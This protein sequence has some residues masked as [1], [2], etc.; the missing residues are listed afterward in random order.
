MK[1]ILP[2]LLLLA[3]LSTKSQVTFTVDNFSDRYF[4][5]LFIS[6]TAEVFSKGWVAIYDKKSKAQLI[7]VSADE[8]TFNL[9]EG[10]VLANIRE[11]PYGE[12][13]QI[14]Y[15]DFNFD[16]RKDFA[17]MDGQ[18]SCYHGPSFR[19]YLAST[20]GFQFSEAFTRL[21][22]EYCGMFQIDVMTKEIMT[23]TK[24]G[25]CW[26]QFSRFRVKDNKPYAVLVIEEGMG[27]TGVTW[28]YVKDSLVNGKMATTRV[29]YLA[30]DEIADSV[31]LKM[32]FDN[33]K[34][35]QLFRYYGVLHY[36]FT[37]KDE[38]IELLFSDQFIY[39]EANGVLSFTRGKA[40]YLITNDGVTVRDSGKNVEI[41]AI[42][43]KTTGSLDAM[44]ALVLENVR[45]RFP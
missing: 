1:S 19:I 34:W 14:I 3:M 20:K 30:E 15:E 35:L 44:K 7:K 10:K 31:F 9:H 2:V 5:R 4:G 22:Q 36:A 28:D 33:G 25:C 8:L 13:S 24:S 39:D 41:K 16:G 38:T 6:D 37:A 21:A 43:G 26:H 32:S 23:M 42:P 27:E 12:Q 11:L 29:S 40:E 17:I 18:N 45:K